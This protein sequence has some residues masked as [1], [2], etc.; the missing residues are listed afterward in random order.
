MGTKFLTQLA[1]DG[2]GDRTISHTKWVASGI[3]KIAIA[4][5]FATSNPWPNAQCLAKTPRPAE[6]EAYTATEALGIIAVIDRVDAK[7]AFSFACFLGM[8][9]GEIQVL[10]WEDF[11]DGEARIKRA[12]SRTEVLDSTKTGK[13]R[14]GLIIEAVK[15][16]LQTWRE[17]SGNP[18]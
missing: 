9:K 3:Y 17:V 5:G 15:S 11:V 14:R 13:A 7:L 2:Q 10:K 16:L 6:G 18:T 12:M 8:R 4:K 1:E